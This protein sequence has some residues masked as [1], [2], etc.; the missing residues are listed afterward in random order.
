LVIRKKLNNLDIVYLY[1]K[2]GCM[3]KRGV[4]MIVKCDNCGSEIELDKEDYEV[5]EMMGEFIF[6]SDRCRRRYFGD[7]EDLDY[8]E[9]EED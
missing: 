5:R 8:V 9:V 3:I 1:G 7:L 2:V 6:C 4:V